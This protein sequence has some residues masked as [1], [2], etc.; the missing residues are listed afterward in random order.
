MAAQVAFEYTVAHQKNVG[1]TVNV[2][3][4]KAADRAAVYELVK[5]VCQIQSLTDAAYLEVHEVKPNGQIEVVFGD[6]RSRWPKGVP[7][8]RHET[9]IGTKPKTEVI[10]ARID[11]SKLPVITKPI[12]L[13]EHKPESVAVE[14]SL[15]V[16]TELLDKDV[17][18]IKPLLIKVA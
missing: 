7:T 11:A 9:I 3:K 13:I 14:Q 4:M 8:I 10:D 18:W 16:V 12:P 5:R 2:Y 1:G 15:P 17:V 6:I